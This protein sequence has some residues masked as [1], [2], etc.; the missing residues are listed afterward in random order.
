M[1]VNS[2]GR[3]T[4]LT[5]SSSGIASPV[6]R[7]DRAVEVADRQLEVVQAQLGGEFHVFAKRVG[8]DLD[9]VAIFEFN[10]AEDAFAVDEGSGAAAQDAEHR[11]AAGEDHEAGVAKRD[12]G[13]VE[14]EFRITL[15]AEDAAV[16]DEEAFGHGGTPM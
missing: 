16:L 14:Q 5:S 2:R 9:D 10:G 6:A 11:P 15:A 8:A 3:M 1:Q 7:G 13:M 12:V 4:M